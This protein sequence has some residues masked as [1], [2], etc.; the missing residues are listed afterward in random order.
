MRLAAF[1]SGPESGPLS[2]DVLLPNQLIEIPRP[3]PNRQRRIGSYLI[4][5]GVFVAFEQPVGHCG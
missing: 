2:K 5:A 4:Q 1:D 3:H